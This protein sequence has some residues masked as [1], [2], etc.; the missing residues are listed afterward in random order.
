M[1]NVNEVCAYLKNFVSSSDVEP[2]FKLQIF[3]VIKEV[4]VYFR[5]RIVLSC[6]ILKRSYFR[7]LH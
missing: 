4:G 2:H 1:I 6:L 5:L 7:V 3:S